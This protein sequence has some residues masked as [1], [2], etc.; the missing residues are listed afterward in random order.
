MSSL[1]GF[2]YVFTTFYILHWLIFSLRS[3]S[4]E[5]SEA[6][7]SEGPVEANS[8]PPSI[9]PQEHKV[10]VLR[11]EKSYYLLLH[12]ILLSY[13]SCIK[14]SNAHSFCFIFFCIRNEQNVNNQKQ[15]TKEE[16]FAHSIVKLREKIYF[17]MDCDWENRLSYILQMI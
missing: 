4:N 13:K 12:S 2:G 7:I 14:Y 3:Y 1:H 8:S 9:D 15:D 17:L 11:F 10:A 6:R 5:K 16:E